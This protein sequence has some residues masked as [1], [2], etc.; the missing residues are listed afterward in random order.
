MGKMKSAVNK[1][2]FPQRKIFTHDFH[3]FPPGN[4]QGHAAVDRINSPHD[5]RTSAPATYASALE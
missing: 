4:L 3:T 1:S 2:I 5:L